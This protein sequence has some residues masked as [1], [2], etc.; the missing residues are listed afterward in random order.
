MYYT[1]IARAVEQKYVC[2]TDTVHE[3]VTTRAEVEVSVPL[4]CV[5]HYFNATV[6]A[7]HILSHVSLVAPLNRRHTLTL[8]LI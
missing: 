6:S 2:E 4:Q 8:T 1:R 3:R 7:T 5:S